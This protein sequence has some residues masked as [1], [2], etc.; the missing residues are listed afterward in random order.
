MSLLASACRASPAATASMT[1]TSVTPSRALME[2]LAWTVT[3]HT[4]A[5]ALMATPESIARWDN[6]AMR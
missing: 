1:S 6:I 2:G 4:N 5:R 3:G